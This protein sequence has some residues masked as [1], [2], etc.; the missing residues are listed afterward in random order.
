MQ[1][2]VRMSVGG[3]ALLVLQL[4]EAPNKG[5]VDVL[6]VVITMSPWR[7]GNNVGVGKRKQCVVKKLPAKRK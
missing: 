3:E 2:V 7:D 4:L 5:L 6:V 1:P